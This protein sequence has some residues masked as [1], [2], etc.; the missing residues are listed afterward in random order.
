MGIPHY[1]AMTAAEF[2]AA[3]SLPPA[4]A[5]MACHFSP[6]GTGLSN[7]PRKLPEGALLVLDD[8]TPICGH[9]PNVI[10]AQLALCVEARKCRGV[11]LDFQ[12]EGYAEAAAL[13]AHLTSTLPFPVCVTAGYGKD[14]TCPILL[15]PVPCDISLKDYLAPWQGREIW[16]ETA[17]DGTEIMLTEEGSSIHPLP[18]PQPPADGFLEETLHCHYR[19]ETREDT[20]V[21]SLWRTQEDL[22]ALLTEAEALGVTLAVGLYQ[23]FGNQST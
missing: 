7:L 5:W 1:L 21:F 4:P 19:I 8:I 15:P 20:A 22:D 10:E 9:D 12:R 17:L 11:L 16:L 3:Q 13:A 6:Y 18:H 2:R 14:L 23:E